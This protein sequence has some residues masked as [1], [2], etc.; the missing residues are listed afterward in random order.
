M[1]TLYIKSV[2]N[3][4]SE[5]EQ[6]LS[7]QFMKLCKDLESGDLLI[8]KAAYDITNGNLSQN[9]GQTTFGLKDAIVQIW[10]GNI[11]K[12]IGH[13][14]KSLV[15]VH[16][17]KLVNLKLLSPRTHSDRSGIEVTEYYRLTELGYK[18][19]RYIYSK[20]V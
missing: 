15:E 12:Q 7:Y 14:I 4:S 16:E 20:G 5:K 19:C 3:S 17:D 18:I 1:K 9:F 6:I 10:L 2:A 8:L 13:D 11:S